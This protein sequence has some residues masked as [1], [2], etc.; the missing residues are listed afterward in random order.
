MININT[1]RHSI[2]YL[3]LKEKCKWLFTKVEHRRLCW[4]KNLANFSFSQSIQSTLQTTKE[5]R[6]LKIGVLPLRFL[7]CDLRGNEGV[8][9]LECIKVKKSWTGLRRGNVFNCGSEARRA[10]CWRDFW[11]RN[12]DEPQVGAVASWWASQQPQLVIQQSG[13]SLNTLQPS[14]GCVWFCRHWSAYWS[15]KLVAPEPILSHWVTSWV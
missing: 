4:F 1:K 11:P 15:C 9:W 12:Q 3:E 6:T 2:K 5:K 13:Q 14:V 8:S 10:S 7:K